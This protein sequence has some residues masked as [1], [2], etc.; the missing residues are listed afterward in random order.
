[1][2]EP[3]RRKKLRRRLIVT[4]AIPPFCSALVAIIAFRVRLC[5]R[6]RRRAVVGNTA[7]A[8]WRT[9]LTPWRISGIG[10][11][12]GRNARGVLGRA[13]AASDHRS[14]GQRTRRMRARRPDRCSSRATWIPCSRS[15]GAGGRH[16][17]PCRARRPSDPPL[18]TRRCS[19]GREARLGGGGHRRHDL[20]TVDL[21]WWPG[22]T[23]PK[24]SGAPPQPRTG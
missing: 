3:E 21:H 12:A 5:A 15:G 10:S 9:S 16:W 4:G 20:T 14:R 1:M 23:S 6:G 19:P 22:A 2:P 13:P 24:R 18:I 11:G 7:I 8:S 17:W